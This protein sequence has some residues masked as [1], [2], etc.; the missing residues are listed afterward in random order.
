MSDLDCLFFGY[1]KYGT[2]CPLDLRP[3]YNECNE[4]RKDE[5]ISHNEEISLHMNRKP[6]ANLETNPSCLRRYAAV[7]NSF[8]VAG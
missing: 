1:E 2:P 4:R 3:R 5:N 8:L 6:T 7:L